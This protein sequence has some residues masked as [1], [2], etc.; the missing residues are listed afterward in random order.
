MTDLIQ[1]VV[2]MV[3]MSAFLVTMAMWIGAL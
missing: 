2:S 3:C 1:D